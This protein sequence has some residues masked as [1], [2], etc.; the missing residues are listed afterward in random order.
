[1]DKNYW[2]IHMGN[3]NSFANL[4]YESGFIAIGWNDFDDLSQYK[5]LDQKNFIET[6]N[7]IFDKIHPN[8]SKG[9]RG[10]TIGQIFRFANLVNIGDI[11]VMPKTDEGKVFIGEITSDYYYDKHPIAGC[12]YFHRRTVKWINTIEYSNLSQ[13]LRNSI[14]SIMT[15]FSISSHEEEIVRLLSSDGINTAVKEVSDIR[16]FGMESHLE[17]FIIENWNNLKEFDDFEI[18]R[19]EGSIF[20]Q[21]YVT[22]IGRIDILAKSKNGKEWIVIELKKGKTADAVTGQ[23]LRYMGWISKNMVQEEETV[24]GIIISGENDEKLKYAI[25]MIPNVAQYTYK[26]N[27][28]LHK[29]KDN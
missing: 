25:S 14:G 7:P 18:L 27:F 23:V 9:K 6:L 10:Q 19:E 17:D 20:G 21:Q 11:I 12:H 4:A 8:E 26:V 29:P 1:M 15:F 3:S 22:P 13:S 5:P 24:R 28:E 2:A 16:E